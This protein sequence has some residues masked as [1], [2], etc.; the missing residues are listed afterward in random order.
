MTTVRQLFAEEIF[1][2]GEPLDGIGSGTADITNVENNVTTINAVITG[3]TGGR[4]INEIKPD[5]LIHTR[6]PTAQDDMNENWNVGDIWITSTKAY[7]CM[8]NVEMM[9]VWNI[10]NLE[11]RDDDVSQVSTYSSNKIEN[12]HKHTNEQTDYKL[13]LKANVNDMNVLLSAKLNKTQFTSALL[14][15]ADKSDTYT[16]NE[17]NNLMADYTYTKSDT[18]NFLHL[19]AD[20]SDTYTKSETNNF[21][22]L[23]ADK[24]NTYT[25]NETNNL[26]ADAKSETNN[27]MTLKAD[28]SNTYTKSDTNN[29]MTLKADK[30]DTYTKN[31]TDNFLHLKADK[32]DTYTKQDIDTLELKRNN[33]MTLKAD[34]SDTYTKSDT[35]NLLDLKADKS[36]TYTKQYIDTLESKRN[37]LLDLKADKSDTFTKQEVNSLM[38]SKSNTGDCFLKA[39]TYDRTTIDSKINANTSADTLWRNLMSNTIND[40]EDAVD[41]RSLTSQ[42]YTKQE[43]NSLID[44]TRTTI[45]AK[46]NANTSADDVWRNLMTT[47]ITDLENTIDDRALKSQTYTK[48]EV[49]DALEVQT[50]NHNTQEERINVSNQISA[51]NT[52]SIFENRTQINETKSNLMF[53]YYNKTV[54]DTAMNTKQ[55]IGVSYNKAEIDTAMNTKQNIGVSYNKA[56]I[57][58]MFETI[59]TSIEELDT[60]NTAQLAVNSSLFNTMSSVSGT[61]EDVVRGIQRV[62]MFINDIIIPIIR[63]LSPLAPLF[64]FL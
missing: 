47:T 39:E 8:S 34:K 7:V 48:Q 19:K 26:M 32:S 45:D 41:S 57:D 55:N 44:Q 14:S 1:L 18:D 42:T 30:S 33:M 60:Q 29:L 36:N 9:A 21:L 3:L 24:S 49:D 31:E 11:I 12:D 2:K 54:I 59:L 6:P 61:L 50:T 52:Y 13:S 53:N 64:S 10:C 62:A 56:E 28:K 17:T 20:K 40:L 51:N 5:P 35:D 4:P 46:I 22:H 58:A 63:A 37:N 38:A 27:M 23:K 15:K 25:K 16:K 43:V